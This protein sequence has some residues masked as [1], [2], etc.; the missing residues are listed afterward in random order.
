MMIITGFL[1]TIL[2]SIVLSKSWLKVSKKTYLNSESFRDSTKLGITITSLAFPFMISF[3]NYFS[4]TS[5]WGIIIA[6]S[7]STFLGLWNNFSLATLTDQDGKIK[8]AKDHNNLMPVILVFQFFL[9]ILGIIFAISYAEKPIET[10]RKENKNIII[11]SNF[12]I[13]NSKKELIRYW[14]VPEKETKIDDTLLYLYTNQFKKT[15]FKIINDTIIEI[16]ERKIKSAR[17]K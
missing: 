7:I 17:D 4:K 12:G 10:S 1:I 11:N 3:S 5:F 16:N 14:G 8:I 9:M 13:G 15:S 6:F 2:I